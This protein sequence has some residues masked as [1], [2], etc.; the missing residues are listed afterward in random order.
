MDSN[1][2]RLK[3]DKLLYLLF[4]FFFGLCAGETEV[5]HLLTVLE[6]EDGRD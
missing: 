5:A 2:K 4:K 3:S 6:E 1:R